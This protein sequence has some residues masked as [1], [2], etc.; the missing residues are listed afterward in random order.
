[1][2]RGD[3]QIVNP[4]N[5]WFKWSGS[6]GT[7][8]YYDKE[9]KE[10][11]EVATP[12]TFL[13]LETY[14]TI[15]GFDEAANEGIFANEV[16]DVTKQV[17]KVKCGKET[18]AQGLYKDIKDAVIARG[19]GYAQSAYVAYKDEDGKLAIGNITFS[20][21][22]FGGGTHKPADKN[23]KDVEVGAWLS[24]TKSHAADIYKKAI[25]IEGK[26]DRVCTQ[27]AVKFYV[28]KFKLIDVSAETDKEAI[29]LTNELKAYMTE[30]FKKTQGEIQEEQVA[31]AVEVAHAKVFNNNA[32][33]TAL[34]EAEQLFLVKPEIPDINISE[35]GDLPTDG[36]EDLPF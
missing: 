11:V 31:Q 27:G 35:I 21:S 36:Q 13:L 32:G 17:L 18:I 14:T 6:T 26:D 33:S 8:S 4:S 9:K 16:K 19:G 24:F 5:K 2:A 15:K 7:L 12:F 1:M 29:E 10:N 23:M 3:V 25:V 34:T 28:P 30:Y 20:G 22:S